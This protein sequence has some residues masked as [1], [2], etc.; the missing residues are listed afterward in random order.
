MYRQKYMSGNLEN[1]GYAKPG[2]DC[3]YNIDMM[4]DAA[5]IIAHG[6]GGMTKCVYDAERRVERVPAPKDIQT[7]AAKVEALAAEKGKLFL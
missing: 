1:V 3:V 7:Y 6:A 2:F 4:E 5:S